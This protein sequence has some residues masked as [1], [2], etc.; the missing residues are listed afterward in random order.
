MKTSVL[1]LLGC[2]C[3]APVSAQTF[4]IVAQPSTATIYR[5]RPHDNSLV[6]IGTGSARFKVEKN[7]PNTV[8]VRL[9]GYQDVTQTFVSGTKFP[10]NRFNIFLT[11]RVVKLST[12][13]FDANIFVNGE[14]RGQRTA[15][16]EIEAGHTATVQLKKPGFATVERV[17]R[18]EE[19]GEMPPA[20]D[21]LELVD[22]L[23]SVTT[24]PAGGEILR[25]DVKV[26]EGDANVVVAFGSCVPIQVRKTGWIP[27]ER[28]Y[29]NKEGQPEPPMA[30]RITLQGRMVN[31]TAPEG[32][33]IFVNQRQA[34]T[35]S[36]PVRIP[37]GSCVQVRV[38]Q[39][40]YLAENREYCAQ[41]N[42]PAPPLDEAFDLRPDDS[43][44]AS[45]Q[46]DQ[47]NVNVTI[48]VGRDRP[49][50]QAWRL[51]SSIVLSYFDVL[52]NSDSDTGYL[53][54]AWQ[55]KNYGDGEVVIRTRIIVKRS[56]LSPLRYTVKIDS[57]RNRLPGVT[58]KEDENF[59]PWDR[60]LNTYKD[61]ISEMQ[62][63]MG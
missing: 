59:V 10:D 57:E 2:L 48:E 12:L 58:V 34:G 31:V 44:S 38:E 54:T 9:E 7:D 56:N 1:A 18:H 27:E 32:G 46:S 20:S 51:L 26:G 14:A 30:D 19:G 42:A 63:R 61:V 16:V 28:Q 21:R 53:R 4:T 45:V 49:E 22:R 13:P 41:P 11:K 40:G 3:A 17:Y 29:C 23:V 43:F 36:F 37:E 6:S 25:A 60:L 47:A 62:A 35:G 50:E 24:S 5:I 33:R 52:E 15:E 8:V 39:P 55:I